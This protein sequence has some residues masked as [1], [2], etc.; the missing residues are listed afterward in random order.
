[1]TPRFSSADLTLAR[2]IEA[3]HAHSA[4]LFAQQD[5]IEA[6]AGGVAVYRGPGSPMTQATNIGMNGPVS[7]ADL[8]RLE[9]FFHDRGSPAVI[10]LCTLADAGLVGMIHE[11]GYTLREISN[12]MARRV[13]RGEE[14]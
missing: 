11:R 13:D 9:A 2:R 6:V 4:T 10:D 14:F 12:V 7:P 8:D 5:A 1:M 3:G